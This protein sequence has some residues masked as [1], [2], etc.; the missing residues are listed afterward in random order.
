MNALESLFIGFR[1]DT[2]DLKYPTARNLEFIKSVLQELV[3]YE[4]K[5]NNEVMK[6]D[7]KQLTN[8]Y[9]F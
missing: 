8:I 7:H 5:K 4:L 2:I 1:N 3:Q 9:S 6:I